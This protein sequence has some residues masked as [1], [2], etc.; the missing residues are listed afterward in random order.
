MNRFRHTVALISAIVLMS[1]GAA[2]AADEPSP[3]EQNASPGVVDKVEKGVVKG[4]KATGRGIERAAEATARGVK[5]GAKAVAKGV[6]R[7]AEAVGHAAERVG[8]KVSGSQ[9]PSRDTGKQESTSP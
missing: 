1:A 8:E 5:R 2:A 7:G 6:K 9:S 4:A 3:K